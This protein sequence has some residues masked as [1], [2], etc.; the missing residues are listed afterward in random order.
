MAVRSMTHRGNL[1]VFTITSNVQAYR[2]R[3]MHV[4][5]KGRISPVNQVHVSRR[6][7][8]TDLQETYVFAIFSSASAQGAK[9]TWTR[10]ERI[11]RCDNAGGDTGDEVC[12]VGP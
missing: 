6:I 5:A 10:L 7:G 2:S 1:T 12:L 3:C 4:G 8:V 9:Y 11:T